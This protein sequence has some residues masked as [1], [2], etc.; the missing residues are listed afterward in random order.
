MA[1]LGHTAINSFDVT[2]KYGDDEPV[3]ESFCGLNIESGL[4]YGFEFASCFT[5]TKVNECHDLTVT[6]QLRQIPTY[7]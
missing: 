3:M 7:L 4:S 5:S 6:I 1:N 2:Y